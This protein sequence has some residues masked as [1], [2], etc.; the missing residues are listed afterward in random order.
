MKY[1][2][3]TDLK[4]GDNLIQYG[5]VKE[6]KLWDKD[7]KLPKYI[8]VLFESQGKIYSE[9]LPVDSEVIITF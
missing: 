3:A 7:P 6:I 1:I 5:K 9:F 8:Q 4:E 2:K